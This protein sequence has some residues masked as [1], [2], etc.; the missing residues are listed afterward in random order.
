M[1]KRWKKKWR[2]RE[3]I[4][5][6]ENG[7]KEKLQRERRKDNKMREG[8]KR[9]ENEC[10]SEE[11]SKM[12]D[13]SDGGIE[14]NEE[15][16]KRQRGKAEPGR[17]KDTRLTNMVAMVMKVIKDNIESVRLKTRKG[18]DIP[19]WEED[20]TNGKELIANMDE[21][22]KEART[23]MKPGNEDKGEVRRAFIKL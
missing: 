15:L 18:I 4:R 19:K 2:K 8:R 23:N 16:F 22:Q 5:N 11:G 10:W 1:A 3:L 13:Q 9:D 17:A 21:D 6:R 14:F 7:R 20:S 12:M